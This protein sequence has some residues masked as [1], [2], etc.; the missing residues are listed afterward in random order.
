MAGRTERPISGH[1][2]RVA[3][4]RRPVWRAKYRLPDGRQVQRTLGP[5][6]TERG[7]PPRGH[8]T[9]RTAEA[10][11]RSTL[12]Q[13]RAGT[14]PGLHPTGTTF[15]QASDEYLQHLEHD[16][17]RKPSTLRDYRSTITRHLLPA[18]GPSA[19]EEVTADRVERWQRWLSA[20][21]ISNRTK[22]KTI[23]ILHGVMERARRQHHL[24]SN[25]AS[26]LEK[27]RTPA[28][29]DIDVFNR[30]EVRALV[31]AAESEQDGAIYLAAAFTGLRQGELL[32][33]RWRNVDFTG[34][35]I[36]IAASYVGGI[37]S[38][39]KSGRIRSVPLSCD[40][41]Q[42]LAKLGQR[43]VFT[44]DDDLV[45]VG[46]AGE[47]L[48]ASALR[49]RYK[50]ALVEAG[51]R[52]LRFHDL[53]HTFGTLAVSG[54]AQLLQ[55]QAWMGHADISTTMV[56][57]HYAPS[58]GEADLLDRALG[59]NSSGEGAAEPTGPTR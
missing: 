45:F 43:G 48:D 49:R 21:P 29:V 47:H 12:D 37:V 41:A 5:A 22:S 44:G 14:L 34:R 33:L 54:G 3:G 9:K 51:L 15:A 53:R 46:A 27:P 4:K 32:A 55:V 38:T 7:R 25:P 58:A 39:P 2:F 18:F 36:R 6:W 42:V 56:Y 52:P 57:L 26:Y 8:Y 19:V 10:W 50:Q 31:R 59:A 16:R 11:L 17:R 20:Q 40:V 1:V 30:E 24:P 35:R 28:R 13:A 23:T